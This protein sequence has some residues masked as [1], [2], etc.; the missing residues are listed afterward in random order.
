MVLLNGPR[1]HG[2]QSRRLI[3]VR[4]LSTPG[5]H[6]H[7]QGKTWLGCALG[8][9]ACREGLTALYLRLPR[10]LQELPIAKG[11]GR[12]GKVLTTLAKT[13]LL[14]LDDWGLEPL[15]PEQRRDLLDRASR[16]QQEQPF[17][18]KRVSEN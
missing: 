11:D 2:A 12:Y 5:G 4:T 18:R 10:F 17:D 7:E 13:D 14:I 16:C 8:H 3:I 1:G 15:G 9:K 6:C